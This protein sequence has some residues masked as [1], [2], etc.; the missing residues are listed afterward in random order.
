MR[1]P[2]HDHA[3]TAHPTDRVFDYLEGRLE[4]DQAAAIDTHL[5]QCRDCAELF[6]HAQALRE[7]V[8]ASGAR[9]VSPQRLVTLAD[10][11]AEAPSASAREEEHLRACERCRRELRWLR[12][13]DAPADLR[14]E[15]GAG[16]AAPA[17]TVAARPAWGDIVQRL[18]RKPRAL[19]RWGWGAIGAAAVACVA[20]L[21]LLQPGDRAAQIAALARTEP[22]TVLTTRAPTD[23]AQFDLLYRE[24]LDAYAAAD[25]RA[26]SAHLALAAQLDPGHEAARLYLGSA[27]LLSGRPAAAVEALEAALAAGRPPILREEVTWQLANAHLAAGRPGPAMAALERVIGW[28]GVHADAARALR[29]E[30]R[31]LTGDRPS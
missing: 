20:V 23:D 26:A 28:G 10:G 16:E 21:V 7:D 27:Y 31:A 30:L 3:G 19:P 9:H 14:A 24:G 4:P 18:R 13:L 25:Y 8:V 11:G 22:L 12:D 5:E 6:G 1:S 29:R 17:D 2:E 15:N